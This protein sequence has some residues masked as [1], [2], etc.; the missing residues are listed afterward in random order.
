[1][2]GARRG[3]LTSIAALATAGSLAGCTGNVSSDV[4]GTTENTAPG[5]TVTS[6]DS[7]AS[8]KGTEYRAVLVV[9]GHIRNA[10]ESPV[11]FPRIRATFYSPSGDEMG[12]AEPTYL[13][14]D[15]E[16]TELTEAPAEIA[17]GETVEFRFTFEPERTVSEFVVRVE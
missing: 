3:F 12:Q 4:S 16:R 14:V 5:L 11:S 1:M 6:V 7:W 10:T 17:A 15:G 9:H 8:G 2:D 13:V